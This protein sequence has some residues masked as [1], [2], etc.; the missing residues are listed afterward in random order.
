L[1]LSDVA[2]LEGIVL[3][4]ELDCKNGL[5]GIQRSA[6]LDTTKLSA[7][8]KQLEYRL[9]HRFTRHM[10]PCRLFLI[11]SGRGLGLGAVQAANVVFRSF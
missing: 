8:A 2:I 5:G 3:V 11:P 6:F 4:D 1:L 9:G 10:L 7:I